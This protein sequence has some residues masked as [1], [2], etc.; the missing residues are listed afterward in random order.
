MTLKREPKKR[1]APAVEER[2]VVHK[3]QANAGMRGAIFIEEVMADPKA[4]ADL[5]YRYRLV[6]HESQSAEE[7]DRLADLAIDLVTGKVANVAYLVPRV[8]NYPPLAHGTQVRFF[9]AEDAAHEIKMTG[10]PGT[11]VTFVRFPGQTE[12]GLKQ[13]MDYLAEARGE[14][15]MRNPPPTA[16]DRADLGS[17]YT[18]DP[19]RKEF[20]A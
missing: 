19:N 2:Y 3:T 8:R 11:D 14:Y 17:Y 12:K 10:K 16:R 5:E 1:E 6:P 20:I 7:F 9:I 18:A 4:H 13:V 15:A